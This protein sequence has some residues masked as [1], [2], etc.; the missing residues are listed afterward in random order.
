MNLSLKKHWLTARLGKTDKT[1]LTQFAIKPHR[2]N[3]IIEIES[4]I[5]HHKSRL[6]HWFRKKIQMRFRVWFSLRDGWRSRHV[7]HFGRDVVYALDG[8]QSSNWICL[9]LPLIFFCSQFS[10]PTPSHEKKEHGRDLKRLCVCMGRVPKWLTLQAV[11][12]ACAID[13]LHVG[14][15]TWSINKQ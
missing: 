3:Q 9:P 8:S 12:S 14:K 2:N 7:K 11:S 4:I 15:S 1:A 10:Y 6:D 5:K 13:A